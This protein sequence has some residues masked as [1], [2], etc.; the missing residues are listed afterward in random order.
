MSRSFRDCLAFKFP[1]RR[2]CLLWSFPIL[3]L[4]RRPQPP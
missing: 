1:T 2:L 3:I 4:F